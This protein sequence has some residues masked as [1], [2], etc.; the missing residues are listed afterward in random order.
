MPFPKR[1]LSELRKGRISVP[2]ARYFVTAVTRDRSTGLTT[3]PIW[4]KLLELAARNEADVWGLVLMP[5]HW[6]ALFVLPEDTMPGDVVR[7]LKGPLSPLLRS[8]GLGWQR[9]Y[10]E[11]RLRSE[12]ES[13]PYLRYMMANPY[14]AERLPLHE[15]WPFWAVTS[16]NAAWFVKKYPKQI[17]EPEWLALEKPWLSE[18]DSEI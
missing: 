1:G 7:A 12:D 10:H 4:A 13:E 17:P 15:R 18:E 16:P 2:G 3:W 11:H 6:H 14:R 5:D 9:G 8:S